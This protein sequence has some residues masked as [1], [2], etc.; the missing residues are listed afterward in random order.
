MSALF[1]LPVAVVLLVQGRLHG[2]A[3]L[4]A[5]TAGLLSSVVPYAADLIALRRIPPRLF[6]MFVSVQPVLAA[7]AG[8][9]LLGQ[10]LHAH[11]WAGIAIV[12]TVNALAVG[13]AARH[14]TP[15]VTPD[16]APA[17][18]VDVDLDTAPAL[19]RW[20]RSAKWA[21]PEWTVWHRRRPAA[22][23]G[24]LRPAASVGIRG[25][26]GWIR[27]GRNGYTGHSGCGPS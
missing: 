4:Y 7:L 22:S 23:V 11:E 25:P 21:C 15:P 2:S 14:G 16:P 6:G 24:I 27:S 1:Y 9:V 8:L 20:D 19:T 18:K 26:A 3:L 17:A 5:L 10:G 13:A 12:I